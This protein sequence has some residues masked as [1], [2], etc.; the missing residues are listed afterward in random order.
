MRPDELEALAR[1]V[2]DFGFQI[3][4]ALGPGLLEHA[5][6]ALL[7]SALLQAGHHVQRRVSIPMR[8]N[9]VVVD[10]AFKIDLLIDNNLIVE[11]K[12]NERLA[13]VHS[14]QVL[15]YLRLM[16][17]P[18]GIL[19]NFGQPLFKDGLKRIANDYQGPFGQGETS[20]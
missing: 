12:S 1:K 19:M 5:Y 15:T 13:A 3:H 18:L 17:L 7:E 6:E 9:G 16:E 20:L 4:L 10:N 2:I 14:K 11:L 8:F